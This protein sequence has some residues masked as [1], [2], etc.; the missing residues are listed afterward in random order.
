MLNQKMKIEPYYLVIRFDPRPHREYVESVAGG[1]DKLEVA[2]SYL[3]GEMGDAA[4]SL[5]GELPHDSDVADDGTIMCDESTIYRAGADEQQ[6]D[7][8]SEAPEWNIYTRFTWRDLEYFCRVI[9]LDF[10]A[11]GAEDVTLDALGFIARGRKAQNPYKPALPI[12][13]D[14]LRKLVLE[15]PAASKAAPMETESR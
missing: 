10:H 6:G 12:E 9:R 4:D 5:Y 2:A 1:S 3:E 14:L 15:W 7:E 11:I 8:Y 13:L